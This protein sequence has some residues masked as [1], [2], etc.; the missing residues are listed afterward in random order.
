MA[1]TRPGGPT[2]SPFGGGVADRNPLRWDGGITRGRFPAM[3]ARMDTPRGAAGTPTVCASQGCENLVPQPTH[4]GPPRRYCS[5]GCRSADRRRRSGRAGGAKTAVVPLSVVHEDGGA[6]LVT[7]L[8]AL[9]ARLAE[10]AHAV[11]S[12]LV[13]AEVDAVSARVASIEATAAEHLA[14]RQ[15]AEERQAGL[16]AEEAAEVAEERV[17]QLAA[18]ADQ[19]AASIAALT[20]SLRAAEDREAA[21]TAELAAL[22]TLIASPTDL[23]GEVATGP[24]PTERKPRTPRSAG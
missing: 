17:A 5:D 22:R 12:A 19:D 7:E 4:G 6:G 20:R 13:E 1:V 9:S 2:L 10:L 23:S 16:A 18:Q 8:R 3:M 14:E 11:D 15:A 21:L 24:W